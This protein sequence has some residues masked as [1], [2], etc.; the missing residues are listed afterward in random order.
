MVL[1]SSSRI[2]DG[3]CLHTHTTVSRLIWYKKEAYIFGFSS[4]SILLTSEL[5]NYIV[6]Y[7]PVNFNDAAVIYESVTMY[8][9]W[10]ICILIHFNKLVF[11]HKVQ[12]IFKTYPMWSPGNVVLTLVFRGKTLQWSTFFIAHRI[13]L[14]ATCLFFKTRCILSHVVCKAVNNVWL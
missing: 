1:L 4:K 2:S 6:V 10:V 3:D 11:S 5:Q 13:H 14:S 9:H 7:M 12:C 8:K